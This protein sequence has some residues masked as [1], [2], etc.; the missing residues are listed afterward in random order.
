M[1]AEITDTFDSNHRRLNN[2]IS[3]YDSLRTANQGRAS[4]AHLEILRAS[5]VLTHSTMEDFIRSLQ[6]WK[7]PE[8]DSNKLS[9]IWLLDNPRKTKFTFQEIYKHR[10]LRVETLLKKSVSNF[11]GYQSYNKTDD[12]ASAITSC[13][14]E[15]T[16][17]IKGLF[18]ALGDLMERRHHIVHQADKNTYVGSGHHRYKSLN[19]NTVKHWIYSVDK[20]A[21]YIIIQ[22]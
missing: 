15:V 10:N 19:L 17:N 20:L 13:G 21:E 6:L 5:V 18:P 9:E 16:D 22:L 12:V 3:L 1:I 7:I 2:L 8:I 14:L 4:T 11:L